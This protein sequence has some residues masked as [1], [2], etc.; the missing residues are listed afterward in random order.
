M[1][2]KSTRS[3]LRKAPDASSILESAARLK[4][5]LANIPLPSYTRSN[6]SPPVNG[7]E[8]EKLIKIIMARGPRSILAL[9]L[10]D[11]EDL[12]WLAG[13]QLVSFDSDSGHITRLYY[14]AVDKSCRYFPWSSTSQTRRRHV[15]CRA[16][17]RWRQPNDCSVIWSSQWA[18]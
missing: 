18:W 9:G 2:L 16:T 8:R 5:E 11:D 3:F 17:S 15:V 1:G 10:P 12:E 6:A 4:E 7:W 13:S 14:H